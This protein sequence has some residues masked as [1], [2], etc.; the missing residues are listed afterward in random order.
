[1]GS[2][3]T[4]A[5]KGSYVIGLNTNPTISRNGE[6][7]YQEYIKTV[8][9]AERGSGWD[10][11]TKQPLEIIALT[12]PYGLQPNFVFHGQLKSGSK[13]IA[14]KT[15]YIEHF[16]ET[17][18]NLDA[19][20]VAPFIT[21]EVKTDSDGFFTTTLPQS[22]WWIIASYADNIGT[23]EHEG[24]SYQHNAMAGIWLHVGE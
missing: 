1:M 9:Y 16:E 24:K 12:R 17:P 7:F 14:D 15:I 23:I 18:P 5:Q 2:C 19:L 4:P 20:P 6:S 21:Y 13:P 22:G 3:Y 11:R 8:I 10:Q